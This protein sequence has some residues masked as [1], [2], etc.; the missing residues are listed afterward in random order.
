M[1][2]L[3]QIVKESALMQYLLVKRDSTNLTISGISQK[4]M[5]ELIIK[6]LFGEKICGYG[7]ANYNKSNNSVRLIKLD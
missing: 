7:I 3:E 4:A 5:N 6:N 2:E 1:T